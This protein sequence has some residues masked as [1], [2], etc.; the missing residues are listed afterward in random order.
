MLKELFEKFGTDKARHGYT[1]V[2][3]I[4]LGK[5][6]LCVKAVLEV[7]IGSLNPNASS[8][9]CGYSLPGYSPG[10]SLRVW[11]EWFPNAEIWGIDVEEDCL[12]SEDRIHT[13]LA[14]STNREQ[15]DAVLGNMKFDVIID[16]GNHLPEVQPKT[17]ANLLGRVR[18]GGFY[19]I[20]DVYVW[21]ADVPLDRSVLSRTAGNSSWFIVRSGATDIIVIEK[22]VV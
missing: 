5:I 21:G 14:D 22:G 17:L 20:E 3:E 19:F 10:G 18:S 6:R 12:F 1:Q 11:K 7:G 9:M 8:T 13:A 2:Y 16:D 15:V 4:M